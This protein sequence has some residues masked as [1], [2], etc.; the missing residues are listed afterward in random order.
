MRIKNSIKY[1]RIK[2]YSEEEERKKL[3]EE[4][5]EVFGFSRNNNKGTCSKCVKKLEKEVFFMYSN[6]FGVKLYQNYNHSIH[7][8][9]NEHYYSLLGNIWKIVKEKLGFVFRKARNIA[10]EYASAVSSFLLDKEKIMEIK[11]QNLTILSPKV[12]KNKVNSYLELI[13]RANEKTEEIKSSQKKS[14]A[15]MA[16]TMI[17]ALVLLSIIQISA[18]VILASSIFGISLSWLVEFIVGLFVLTRTFKSGKNIAEGIVFRNNI[19]KSKKVIQCILTMLHHRGKK[20]SSVKEL[21]E[22]IHNLDGIVYKLAE[23]KLNENLEDF[24]QD[25]RNYLETLSDQEYPKVRECIS[26]V[27]EGK[28]FEMDYD[29]DE[30]LQDSNKPKE[31]ADTGSKKRADKKRRIKEEDYAWQRKTE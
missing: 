14:L 24:Y 6:I 17:V 15:S 7:L 22:A 12:W 13:R 1:K 11:E 28:E 9:S 30:L 18:P 26:N 21:E 25:V 29:P 3:E 2:L 16:V 23:A 20:K 19:T 5:E 4:F 27:L 31:E 8:Y 10:D